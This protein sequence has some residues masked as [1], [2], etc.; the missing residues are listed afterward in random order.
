MK[1]LVFFVSLSTFFYSC[2]NNNDAVPDSITKEQLLI[3]QTAQAAPDG[4]SWRVAATETI[5]AEEFA[6]LL[7]LSL[8]QKDIRAFLKEEANKIFDGDFDILVSRVTEVKIGNE[9]F[10]ER[11]KKNAANG[12]AKGQEVFDNA[13][14]NEKLNIS[15]PVLIDNWD[16]L[17]QQPLVAVAMGINEKETKHLKAFDSNG[18]TYLLDANVEPNVPVIVVGNNERMNYKTQTKKDKN[19]R[20]SGNYEK[21]TWIKC[22]NLGAIESWFYGAPELRFEGVV[23]NDSFSSA[24]LAFTKMEY[25][26]SRSHASNGYTLSAW[27]QT[28]NLFEWHFD[29]NHGPDYFIQS[30]EID[31][32]G[33]TQEFTVGVTQGTKATGAGIE[34][35]SSQTATFKLTYKAQDK[36]LAGELIHYTKS[37]PSSISDGSIQFTLEN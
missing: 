19:A 28:L 23:Y 32:D 22:P 12:Y 4:S 20:T 1:K 29:A 35:S 37:S 6:K 25:P 27:T 16:D 30:Y 33:T 26:P 11:V 24:F 13:L 34:G 10:S 9:K 14:K 17:H 18:K 15:I 21:I 36:K 3:P 31:D 2:N 7:A 8:K 5:E